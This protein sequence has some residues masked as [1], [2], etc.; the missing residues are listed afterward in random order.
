MSRDY[1]NEYCPKCHRLSFGGYD[2]GIPNYVD[3]NDKYVDIEK[4]GKYD[5]PLHVRLKLTWE[6]GYCS[7]CKYKTS[8]F[9]TYGEWIEITEV[10]PS[11]AVEEQQKKE[12]QEYL[13]KAQLEKAG[14]KELYEKLK[15]EFENKGK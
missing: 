6:G 4:L 13:E 9:S 14:R 15:K 3:A 5:L 1:F 10:K 8:G 7:D 12:A 11:K 2:A